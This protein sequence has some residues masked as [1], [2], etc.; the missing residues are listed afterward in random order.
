M[1]ARLRLGWLLA[2]AALALDPRSAPIEDGSP[3]ELSCPE[4]DA[5]ENDIPRTRI[6]EA[7]NQSPGRRMRG[8]WEPPDAILM[9]F[10]RDW[11][12]T[13]A[14]LIAIGQAQTGVFLMADPD[15]STI[16]E[17][18]D[19]IARRDLDPDG[20]EILW[21]PYDTPWIRDYGPLQVMVHGEPVWL[22]ADYGSSRPEDDALPPAL[23]GLV[24]AS[25]E[26]LPFRLDGGAIV[27]NGTGLCASTLE[28]FQLAHIDTNDAAVMNRLLDLL[29]CHV[30]ALV[31]ALS[32]E[33]THHA[34]ML[35]QFL[36]PD[37]VA[38]AEVRGAGAPDDERRMNEAVRGLTEAARRL[39]VR[40]RV[41]RV[42]VPYVGGGNYR[43]YVN[44]V[45]LATDF[46]VPG[47]RDVAKPIAEAAYRALSE[48]LPGTNV[49]VVPADEVIPLFG[50]LHCM[51][52]GVTL[53]RPRKPSG[54]MASGPSSP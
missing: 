41:A 37:Q 14:D 53:P 44:G 35:A 5:L 15:T 3:E 54:A 24:G 10:N 42:P 13:L 26:P 43:T 22:D 50:S 8:D 1:R 6:F 21:V 28:Y 31:P 30:L 18:R 12:D 7:W 52:L 29:G 46:V 40:L 27:A 49:V 20:V 2:L 17:I 38:V 33:K 16:E 48:A 34:D 23:A 36:A 32:H 9:T 51:T 47:Y 4:G 11:S 45:R 39:G 19:W 25:V